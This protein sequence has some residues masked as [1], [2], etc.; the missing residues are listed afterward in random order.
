MSTKIVRPCPMSLTG[1]S[2]P[3]RAD[4]RSGH[5]GFHLIATEFCVA[6]EFRDVP[7]GDLMST[8]PSLIQFFITMAVCENSGWKSGT[9]DMILPS[10]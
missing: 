7:K 8:R 10:S 5:V 4:S 3:G 2:R 6:A 9:I 1:Q